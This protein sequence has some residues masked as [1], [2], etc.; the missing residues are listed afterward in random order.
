MILYVIAITLI[1]LVYIVSKITRKVKSLELSIN[2]NTKAQKSIAK[3]Q[4]FVG[5]A[6]RTMGE[7]FQDW[8]K[9]IEALVILEKT[10][11]GLDKLDNK[12]EF[13]HTII[14]ILTIGKDITKI[15]EEIPEEKAEDIENGTS[16]IPPP[17]KLVNKDKN[18]NWYMTFGDGHEHP[19]K[20][21][22]IQGTYAAARKE[23]FARYEDKWGFQYSEEQFSEVISSFPEL[24]LLTTK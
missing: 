5:E 11:V 18:Q 16:K 3:E 22:E 10:K 21:V 4:K 20:Y 1:V 17:D 8:S 13:D 23:M 19:N 24:E 12:E 6:Q 9:Y 14:G 2:E 7:I 15:P